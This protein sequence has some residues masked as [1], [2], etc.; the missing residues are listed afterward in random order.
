MRFRLIGGGEDTARRL[1]AV[2]CARRYPSRLLQ[3][4]RASPSARS[5]ADV[6]LAALISRIF[7]QSHETYGAPRIQAELADD[8][9]IRRPG[10]V[11]HSFGEAVPVDGLGTEHRRG[12]WRVVV[13]AERLVLQRI[14]EISH[15]R[16]HKYL[17]VVVDHDTG[18][19]GHCGG[20]F[21][22]CARNHRI[23]HRGLHQGDPQP[24]SPDRKA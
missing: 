15:R 3:L 5:R 21:W 4:V 12:Q 8:Y 14:D 17:M 9:A 19:R 7:R 2:Q 1:P 11:H 6:K 23:H 13:F 16:G 24:Q 20:S 10:L 22:L 18:G